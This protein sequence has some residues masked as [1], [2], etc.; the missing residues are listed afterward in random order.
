MR[1]DKKTAAV[2]RALRYVFSIK[3]ADEVVKEAAKL[4]EALLRQFLFA[5]RQSS[6]ISLEL[7]YQQGEDFEREWKNAR[8]LQ[9]KE[10]EILL[11]M[12][13]NLGHLAALAQ[14]T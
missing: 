5:S 7:P 8:Q 13:L 14:D 2:P 1:R 12:C 6:I 3:Y 9:Q 11:Q 4:K 10:S